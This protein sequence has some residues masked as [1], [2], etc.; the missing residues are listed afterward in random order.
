MVPKDYSLPKSETGLYR[1]LVVLG[2][3][4][5]FLITFLGMAFFQVLNENQINSS[6]ATLNKQAELASKQIEKRFTA[7][8]DDMSFFVNNLEPETYRNNDSEI[9][10]FEKRARRIFNNHR[11]LLDTIKVLFPDQAVIFHFDNR[12]N[13]IKSKLDIQQINPALG[14][15]EIVVNNKKNQVSIRAFV[16]LERFFIEEM[17][18]YYLGISGVRLF[19]CDGK[20]RGTHQ[21]KLKDGF[22]IEEDI[23]NQ[24]AVQVDEGLK[25]DFRGKFINENEEIEFESLIQHYP[26]SLYPLESKFT[27]VFVVDRNVVTTGIFSTYFYL[28]LALLALLALVILILFKSIKNSQITNSV[29]SKNADEISELFRRYTQ[30]WENSIRSHFT[31]KRQYFL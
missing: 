7:F 9:L 17:T 29:L 23:L 4:V 25:G 28:I 30:T 12:N 22:I 14:K 13:F 5:V 27:T 31:Q 18:Y 1:I 20:L 15:N 19:F 8:Y 26:F 11:D 16:E 6:K 21:Q 10:A 24:L 2:I 3:F